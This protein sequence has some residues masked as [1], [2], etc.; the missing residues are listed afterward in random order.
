M[1]ANTPRARWLRGLCFCCG[2]ALDWWTSDPQPVAEGVMMC[3]RCIENGHHSPDYMEVM[4]RCLVSGEEFP[5]DELLA[6]QG[7]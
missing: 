6:R 5:E 4:L 1:N 2:A 7:P 3:G